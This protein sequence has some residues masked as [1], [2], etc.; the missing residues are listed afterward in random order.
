MPRPVKTSSQNAA[1]DA[2]QFMAA[3]EAAAM[4]GTAEKDGHVSESDVSAEVFAQGFGSGNG[5]CSCFRCL[6]KSAPSTTDYKYAAP[7]HV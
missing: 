5:M 6:R 4:P 1:S 7:P 3:F 2:K